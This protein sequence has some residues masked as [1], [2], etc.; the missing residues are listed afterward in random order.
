[1][2][3]LRNNNNNSFNS[4]NNRFNNRLQ[5][6]KIKLY[7]RPYP[8]LKSDYSPI[9]PLD[10]YQTFTSKNEGKSRIIKNPKS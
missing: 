1:M 7:N 5:I 6:D 10:I 4:F 9:I 8:F 2:L 3:K